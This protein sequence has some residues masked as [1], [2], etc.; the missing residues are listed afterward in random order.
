MSLRQTKLRPFLRWCG[1]MT[2]LV[3]LGA[4][5]F[6]QAHCL[7]DACQD[8]AGETGVH[9]TAASD[10]HHGDEPASHH[11]EHGDDA[12]CA[13]LKSALSGNTTPSLIAPEFSP[14]YTLTP[15]AFTFAAT[16]IKLS[17]SISRQIDRQNLIF[18]PEVC[19]ASALHSLAPPLTV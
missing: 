2:L 10:L 11:K 6:C 7:F 17:A 9:A 18:T 12:S 16:T 4:Q 3:W 1:V 8:E 5:T 14:I 19:L 13:T 15:I